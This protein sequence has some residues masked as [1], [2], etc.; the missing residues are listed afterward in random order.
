MKDLANN[1]IEKVSAREKIVRFQSAIKAGIEAG[2]LQE[3]EVVLK[4]HFV[5]DLKSGFNLYA[6]EL[7][8][9][10]G[11]VVVGKIHKERTLNI[12]SSGKISLISSTGVKIYLE[13]PYTYISEPGVQKAAYI[14]EDVTWI[15]VHI[16]KYNKERDLD[17]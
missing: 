12:L 17:K 8:M 15:N 9:P 11:A 16:T 7:K 14:E 4:H 3:A 5:E 2:D 10:K 1:S 13:A 6:R